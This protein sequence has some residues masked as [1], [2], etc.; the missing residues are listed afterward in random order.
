MARP[1]VVFFDV[2]GTL[3]HFNVEPS[4]MFARI[5]REQ[6][7]EVAPD[8]LYRAMREVEATAPDL[9]GAEAKSEVDY[10]R[11]YDAMILRKVGTQPT[12]AL[13]DE[14]ARRFRTDLTFE[15]YP[16]SVPVLEALKERGFP[17]GVISNASHGIIGDLERVGVTRFFDHIVYSQQV[18]CA[19][20]DA[21]IFREALGRFAVDAGSTWHIGDNVVADVE[22]ARAVG[23][24]PVLVRRKGQVPPPGTDTVDDLRGVVEMLGPR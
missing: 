11:A 14:I 2:G 9:S 13:L 19:K 6:G 12:E 17:L 18:G 4:A 5:V 21:R 10:W 23:I 24:R 8:A 20:P 7:V 15:L 3:M 22:G 16:E 1:S